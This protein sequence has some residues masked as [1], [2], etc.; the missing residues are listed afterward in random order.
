MLLGAQRHLAVRIRCWGRSATWRSEYDVGGAAPPGAQSTMLGT[1]DSV[2][3][4]AGGVTMS[5]RSRYTPSPV[6]SLQAAD[7][8]TPDDAYVSL[9]NEQRDM[10]CT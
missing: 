5:I 7:S 1:T 6:V 2:T 4:F 9:C 3:T 10:V 8:S